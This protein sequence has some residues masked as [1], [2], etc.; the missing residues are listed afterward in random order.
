MGEPSPSLERAAALERAYVVRDSRRIGIV[1]AIAV[2]LLVVLGILL[3]F[4]LR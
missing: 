2:G 4:T 1:T 3:N